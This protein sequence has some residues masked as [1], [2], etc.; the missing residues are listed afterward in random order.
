MSETLIAIK[1]R[2]GTAKKR[3]AHLRSY[4]DETTF[5]ELLNMKIKGAVDGFFGMGSEEEEEEEEEDE[6]E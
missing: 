2:V 5:C 4:D 6:S 1:T 3:R